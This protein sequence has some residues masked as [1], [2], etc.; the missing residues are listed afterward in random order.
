ML[1]RAPW[2]VQMSL[3]SA[4]KLYLHTCHY[5]QTNRDGM[6]IVAYR[7]QKPCEL[8][9]APNKWQKKPHVMPHNDVIFYSLF[10]V[11]L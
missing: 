11:D 8:P 6:I 5:Y 2:V 1:T 10:R 9:V 7:Y 4:G 3:L